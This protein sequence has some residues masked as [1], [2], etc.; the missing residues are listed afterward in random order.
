MSIVFKLFFT[1]L[2]IMLLTALAGMYCMGIENKR[3]RE[4]FENILSKAF[5]VELFLSIVCSILLIWL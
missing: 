2:L 1:W 3:R 5:L 4:F